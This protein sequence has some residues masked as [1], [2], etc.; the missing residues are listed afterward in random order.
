[1]RLPEDLK[2]YRAEEDGF[3]FISPE[4][5]AA[6]LLAGLAVCVWLDAHGLLFR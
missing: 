3:R 1:M 6:L 4:V 2:N 5:A